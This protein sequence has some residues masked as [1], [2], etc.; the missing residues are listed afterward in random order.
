MRFLRVPDRHR[1]RTGVLLAV[2]SPLALVGL[3]LL[4]TGADTWDACTAAGLAVLAASL[5]G[6]AALRAGWARTTA[7]GLCGFALLLLP[8]WLLTDQL[9]HHRGVVVEVTVTGAHRTDG[10]LSGPE[11]ACDLRRT[12]GR[13]LAHPVARN[14]GPSDIGDTVGLL[15]DPGGW[16][17]PTSTERSNWDDPDPSPTPDLVLIALALTAW[18]WTA[19]DTTAPRPVRLP[20]PPLDPAR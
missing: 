6:L 14:C 2:A 10:L 11:W 18:A 4:S 15:V 8:G 17:P 9:R 12:D 16:L 3:D 13:P 1:R 20:L 5:L 7:A 19:L